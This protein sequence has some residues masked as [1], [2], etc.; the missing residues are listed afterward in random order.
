MVKPDFVIDTD[1]GERVLWE[2]LGMMNEPRYAAK[3]ALKKAWYAQNGV[4]SY[5]EG[6]GP[7]GTLVV[8]DDQHGVDYPAWREL[9]VKALG[10]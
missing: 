6:G 1:L 7:R 5:E 3:W 8:T 2:H 4:L 10:L 9:A